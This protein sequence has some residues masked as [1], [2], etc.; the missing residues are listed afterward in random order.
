MIRGSKI[1]L[2]HVVEADLPLLIRLAT[3]RAMGGEFAS[4]AMSS[5]H[6]VRKRF[7][8]DGY[9]SDAFERLMI[10]D[11]QGAVIG[12]VSH[13]SERT[14]SDSREI[15]WFVYDAAKRGK[16]YATE[17]ADLLVKYLFESRPVQRI[18]CTV[19]PENVASRRVAEKCGFSLEGRNR[20]LL[21]VRGDYMDADQFSIVRPEWEERRRSGLA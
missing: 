4:M 17:A 18:A 5:P 16:G 1:T 3:D 20:R 15:G 8:D 14:Y 7:A 2:R 12:D 6:S 10:C 9:S 21:F 11:E 13:F 19:A